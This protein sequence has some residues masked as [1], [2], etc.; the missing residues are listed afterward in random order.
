MHTYTCSIS[1]A[2]SRSQFRLQKSLCKNTWHQCSKSLQGCLFCLFE[3]VFQCT[4]LSNRW[5][6]VW[7]LSKE[8]MAQHKQ[9]LL[10]VFAFF[11][12]N[13]AFAL[14]RSS[15]SACSA[16]LSWT[17][18]HLVQTTANSVDEMHDVFI[19]DAAVIFPSTRYTNLQGSHKTNSKTDWWLNM[20]K[21]ELHNQKRKSA[22]VKLL[23]PLP[24]PC[25]TN[26]WSL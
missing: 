15:K 8:N 11:A 10:Q 26:K 24:Q 23:W 16:L 22:P 3:L 6:K 20:R 14:D 17:C 4:S 19:C 2:W 7:K 5:L 21:Q 1:Y 13:A 25:V 9:S 12:C 18:E